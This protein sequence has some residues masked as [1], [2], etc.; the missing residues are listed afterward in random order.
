MKKIACMIMALMMLLLTACGGQEAAPTTTVAVGNSSLVAQIGG[1][2]VTFEPLEQTTIPAEG[3]W[4]LTADVEMSAPLTVGGKLQLHLNGHKITAVEGVA[5]ENLIAVPAGSELLIYD[6]EDGAGSI[7]SP[8]SFTAKPIIKHMFQVEGTV[9]IAGGTLDASA[10]SLE[11][12][13]NG[14]AF[15]VAEGGVLNIAGGTVVGATTLCTSI[16]TEPKVDPN[17]Q[18]TEADAAAQ[19]GEG[20]QTEEE[21]QVEEEEIPE[22]VEII[23]KGGSVFVAVGGT[24][25]ISGGTVTAGYAGLGGNIFVDGNESGVGQLNISG[26]EI[27]SGEAMFNGGN[28]YVL[29]AAKISDGLLLEG[30]AYSSGGN[31]YLEGTLEMTGG[32]LELG[33]CD[34][35]GRG[36]KRGGNLLVNGLNAVVNISNAEIID[37]DG[38][39]SENFGGSVSVIGQCAREFSITDTVISGGQG[40]RGGNVYIGTLAQDVNPENLDYYMKNVTISGGS[41]SYRGA[42]L[43]MDS[44]LKDVYINLVMDDCHFVT[45][46]ST[47]ETISLGAGAA[48]NTWVTLTMNGGSIEGG[49]LT[50]YGLATLTANG[51]SLTTETNGGAGELV[52]NP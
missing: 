18:K 30:T 21:T 14:G 2:E 5:Y 35:N 28:I 46:D 49:T 52:I 45:E 33:R 43:C 22:A 11:N 47:R 1:A 17:A 32:R 48:V 16:S 40:H 24:C 12:V 31:I 26:G 15:Y 6:A 3:A 13:A 36:G 29:G 25:N 9:T 51:T 38:H 34:Y 41:C 7:V 50:I 37:G 19:E 10:I 42:N 8:R 27:S 39:G 4:Y 20:E 23:G 44:D